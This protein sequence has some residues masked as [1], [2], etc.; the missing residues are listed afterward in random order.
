VEPIATVDRAGPKLP[1]LLISTTHAPAVS[2]SGS[3]GAGLSC[4]ACTPA[5]IAASAGAMTIARRAPHT[6]RVAAFSGKRSAIGE[7]L[8][9]CWLEAGS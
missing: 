6:S 9:N 2:A 8:A 1:R 5:A 7:I 3:G 4:A